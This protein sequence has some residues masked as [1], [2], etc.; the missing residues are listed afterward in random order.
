MPPLREELR[1]LQSTQLRAN[2]LPMWLTIFLLIV[3]FV[4]IKVIAYFAYRSTPPTI[5]HYFIAD[6]SLG[7]ILLIGTILASLVNAMV[8]TAT[9][10]QISEGGILFAFIWFHAATFPFFVYFLGPK[11]Q[12]L[13]EKYGHITLG[14]LLRQS[15][16]SKLLQLFCGAICILSVLPFLIV[17]MVAVGKILSSATNNSIS[18]EA[19]III[20][21]ISVGVYLV[22]GGSRAVVWTDLFQGI[23]FFFIL[24]I[25]A[26]LFIHWTGGLTSSFEKLGH[27]IPEKLSFSSSNT[28]VLIDRLLSWPFAFFLWPHIFQRCFMASSAKHLKKTAIVAAFFHI[29]IVFAAMM[30]GITCTVA[31]VGQS[32]DPDQMV[33]QMF[34]NFWP[35]GAPFIVLMVFATGMSTIDSMLLTSASIIDRDFL[36]S[37]RSQGELRE[38]K[39]ARFLSAG[40]VMVLGLAVIL[41]VGQVAISP[42]TTIGASLATLLLWPLLGALYLQNLNKWLA[43]LPMMLGLSLILLCEFTGLLNFLVL[44]AGSLGFLGGLAGFALSAFLQRACVKRTS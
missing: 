36:S 43:F 1:I 25:T 42:L 33:A 12:K 27:A 7:P 21:M 4:T 38:F 20:L 18:F 9:P 34:R 39:I 10:A 24:M 11:I 28:P 15:Y 32:Y 41:K 37:R 44:G 14:E 29:P 17:Q 16:D 8:V 13:G 19:S 26:T 35:L 3:Y 31:F 6:R 30:I 23:V 2:V 5:E 22:F 40:L